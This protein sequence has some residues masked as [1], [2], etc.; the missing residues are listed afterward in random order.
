M[1]TEKGDYLK[2]C[3]KIKSPYWN[4]P[5]KMEKKIGYVSKIKS[6]YNESYYLIVT[7]DCSEYNFNKIITEKIIPLIK[8]E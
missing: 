4:K 3:S 1:P 6:N 5:R 2:V 7:M 8:E